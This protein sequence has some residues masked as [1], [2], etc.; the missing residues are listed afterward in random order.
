MK[1]TTKAKNIIGNMYR[2]QWRTGLTEFQDAKNCALSAVNLL[3]KDA[4]KDMI[5]LHRGGMTDREYWKAVK[6]EIII[7]NFNVFNP[8]I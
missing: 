3:I 8:M 2:N 4:A 6:K 5:H 1:P 7:C